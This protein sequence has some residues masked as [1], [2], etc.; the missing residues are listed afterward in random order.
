MRSLV[1][2]MLAP[3]ALTPILLAA[4]C[5]SA[6]FFTSFGYVACVDLRNSIRSSSASARLRTLPH[7]RGLPGNLRSH[8]ASRKL[9]SVGPVIHLASPA[10]RNAFRSSSA[11]E[12]MMTSSPVERLGMENLR[13]HQFSINALS[14][15]TVFLLA[16]DSAV[17]ALGP[18]KPPLRSRSRRSLP[19]HPLSARPKLPRGF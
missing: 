11:W 18:A 16:L 6:F 3:F 17:K 2:T 9:F 13:F 8:Q 10:P 19:P 14:L 12:T 15:L 1:G 4:F 7:L 5:C